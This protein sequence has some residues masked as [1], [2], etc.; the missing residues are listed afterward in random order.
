MSIPSPAGLEFRQL[1]DSP[2]ARLYVELFS[3]VVDLTGA[4][5]ALELVLT[6]MADHGPLPDSYAFLVGYAAVAYCRTYFPSKVR[7]PLTDHVSVPDTYSEL[8]AHITDYRNRHVAHSQSQLSVTLA[9]V[10][11]DADGLRPGVIAATSSQEFP[12]SFLKPWIALI[13]HLD[14]ELGERRD[15]VEARIVK[16]MSRLS[17]DEVRAWRSRPDIVE[18]PVSEFAGRRSRGRYPTGWSVYWHPVD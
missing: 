13:D 5:S 3:H 1:P 11:L 18:R 6:G 14:E 7:A 12:S 9:L 17:L 2:D 10:E 16:D 8:H 15:E 4:K